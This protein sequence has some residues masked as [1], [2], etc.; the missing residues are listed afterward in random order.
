MEGS[1]MTVICNNK[2]ATFDVASRES[3]RKHETILP[4]LEL[5]LLSIG[6]HMET[7]EVED[8]FRKVFISLGLQG[9]CIDGGDTILEVNRAFLDRK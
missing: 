6:L 8:A 3:A 9:A 1:H 5:A 4:F 2:P 7:S